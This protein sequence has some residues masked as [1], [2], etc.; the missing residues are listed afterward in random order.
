[1]ATLPTKFASAERAP[2]SSLQEHSNMMLNTELLDKL[3]EA[4]NEIILILNRQLQIVF[5]NSYFASLLG[6]AKSQHL[7]GMR[8]GEALGCVHSCEIDGC[9]TSEFCSMCGAVSAI[10][11]AQQGKADVKECRILRG[12]KSDAMDLLVRATPLKFRGE[13]FTILAA[14]DITHEKRR[15]ALE[16]VFF[17]D[18]MNTAMAI[19]TLSANLG[20]AGLGKVSEIS[21][22][23]RQAAQ[24]LFEEISAQRDLMYA[25]NNELSVDPVEMTSKALLSQVAKTYESLAK[26]RNCELEI[27]PQTQNAVFRSDSRIVARV[28]G[29]MIK[30]AL[31]ACKEASALHWHPSPQRAA[32]ASP[33]ITPAT[34]R[35]RFSCSSSSDRSQPRAPA[36]A[37]APTA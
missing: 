28:V 19:K 23:I 26:M 8:P 13:D 5:C 32:S 1:M 10:L 7:I 27:S 16:R 20:R 37:W 2:A 18:L 14:T 31:E 22:S 9:G 29:N 12:P 11:N 4:V 21:S 36:A 17:H 25:E 34:C 35:A 30:N 15:S 3:C 24:Q 6:Y 33:F